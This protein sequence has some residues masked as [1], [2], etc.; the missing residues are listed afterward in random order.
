MSALLIR[1]LLQE[2]ARLKAAAR[3]GHGGAQDT[4]VVG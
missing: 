3:P 4:D 2:T 1:F